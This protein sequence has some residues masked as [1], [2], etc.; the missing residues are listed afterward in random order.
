MREEKNLILRPIGEE[1]NLLKARLR[2]EKEGP[3]H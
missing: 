2:F 3:N 1:K